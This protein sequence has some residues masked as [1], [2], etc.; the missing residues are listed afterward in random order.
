MPFSNSS[1][2]HFPFSLGFCCGMRPGGVA[3]KP[4]T[5]GA[6]RARLRGAPHCGVDFACFGGRSAR[7]LGRQELLRCG[8]RRQANFPRAPR[9]FTCQ[10]LMFYD[11]IIAV[12]Q[13]PSRFRGPSGYALICTLT[14]PTAFMSRKLAKNMFYVA[15]SY[16]FHWRDYEIYTALGNGQLYTRW[17]TSP[18][19]NA[20]RPNIISI[21]T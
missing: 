19:R 5:R 12:A 21:E 9:M 8:S 14:D 7:L 3:L 13:S 20:W 2:P 18:C 1:Y 6:R 11:S 15:F 10:L 16:Q 4:A 17:K